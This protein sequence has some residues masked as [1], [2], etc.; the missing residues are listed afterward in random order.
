[1]NLA[2]AAMVAS[3]GV[4]DVASNIW[5]AESARKQMD[6]QER[7]YK[8]KT[9]YQA[10]D[11]K[12]AGFNP[13]MAL[14]K[15][16]GPS[17]SGASFQAQ[18]MGKGIPAGIQAAIQM[19]KAKAEI[20]VLETQAEKNSAD[21]ILSSKGSELKF[22]QAEEIANKLANDVYWYSSLK[23]KLSAKQSG[24]KIDEIMENVK[25]LQE[26]TRNEEERRK[27]ISAEKLLKVY[28]G[29]IKSP[30]ARLR[31]GEYG[32]ADAILQRFMQLL[33]IGKGR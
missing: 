14:D 2:S 27:L 15:M 30:E 26:K 24:H 20:A 28:E 32:D 10:E 22:Q 33:R 18:P 16:G 13:I 11:I 8:N 21:A 3:Q 1:M 29:M 5:S 17:P 7:M 23:D 19:K 4:G 31:G 9:Q 12:K 6:F 25:L